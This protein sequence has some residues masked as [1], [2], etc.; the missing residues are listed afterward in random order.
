MD[1]ILNNLSDFVKVADDDSDESDDTNNHH[2]PPNYFKV[3]DRVSAWLDCL[4]R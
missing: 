4:A 2:V 1:R 3:G